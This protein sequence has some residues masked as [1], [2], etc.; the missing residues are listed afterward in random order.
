[1]RA[2]EGGPGCA[3]APTQPQGQ[4]ERARGGGSPQSLRGLGCAALWAHT[5]P[6]Q[7]RPKSLGH[8]AASTCRGPE[9]GSGFPQRPHCSAASRSN[10]PSCSPQPPPRVSGSESRDMALQSP[11][12]TCTSPRGRGG[13]QARPAAPGARPVTCPGQAHAVSIGALFFLPPRNCFVICFSPPGPHA[14]RD[15]HLLNNCIY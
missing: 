4:Q 14:L 7:T 9:G 3:R 5:G 10:E 1:M 6:W 8:W 12:V 11:P 13:T 15:F 2:W